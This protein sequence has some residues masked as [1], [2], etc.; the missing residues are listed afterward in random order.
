[1]IMNSG[2]NQRMTMN[3]AIE[4]KTIKGPKWINGVSILNSHLGNDAA[5]IS[6][7]RHM[8]DKAETL[9]DIYQFNLYKGNQ[10]QAP[11]K[12]ED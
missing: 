6:R 7:R 1:M 12:S 11:E 10:Y 2:R 8:I 9:V 5:Y 4:Y 3:S